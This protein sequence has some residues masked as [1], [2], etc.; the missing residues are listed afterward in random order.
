M[1]QSTLQSIS[2]DNLA[3][4]KTFQKEEY[5]KRF[6]GELKCR[7]DRRK[8]HQQRPIKAAIKENSIVLSRGQTIIIAHLSTTIEPVTFNPISNN[9]GSQLISIQFINEGVSVHSNNSMKYKEAKADKA[10]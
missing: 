2:A 9:F 6:F 4:Y 10:I 8:F 1:N 5:F 7:E 3:I